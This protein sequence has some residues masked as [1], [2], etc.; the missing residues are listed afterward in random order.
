M[1]EIEF[2]MWDSWTVGKYYYFI[3][4]IQGTLRLGFGEI[5]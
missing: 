2:Y 3:I 4:Y 5:K 1:N